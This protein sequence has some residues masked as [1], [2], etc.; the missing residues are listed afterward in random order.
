[1]KDIKKTIGMRINTLLAEHNKRQKDL[2]YFLGVTDNTISYFVNGNRIP[3]TEQI[4]KI[5]EFF[6]VSSDFILGISDVSSIDE[7][8]KSVCEYTGISESAIDKIKELNNDEMIIFNALIGECQLKD[9]IDI[10]LS[11]MIKKTESFEIAKTFKKEFIF[12]CNIP[13]LNDDQF[14]NVAE[15]MMYPLI[16]KFVCLFLKSNCEN[17]DILKKYNDI[18]VL[19]N[20]FLSNNAFSDIK[21]ILFNKLRNIIFDNYIDNDI[22]EFIKSREGSEK[23]N[24]QHPKTW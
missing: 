5:A 17:N 6:N 4:I 22:K 20:D 23:N 19:Y 14:W 12:E 16:K 7:N 15:Y 11:E 24:G 8:L 10:L 21:K 2:A 13:T 9:L 1:M 3:N 18:D